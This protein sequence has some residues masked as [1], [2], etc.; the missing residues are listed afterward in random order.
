[1]SKLVSEPIRS[2]TEKV[3]SLALL[4]PMGGNSYDLSS[5]E[6]TGLCDQLNLRDANLEV[7]VLR[8]LEQERFL[9]EH[10]ESEQGTGLDEDMKHGEHN[11]VGPK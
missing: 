3:G 4:Q 2:T 11:L 10:I 1:M 8:L 5:F 6:L 7:K 9:D